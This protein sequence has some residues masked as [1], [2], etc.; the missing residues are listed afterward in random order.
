MN[1]MNHKT[2]MRQGKQTIMKEKGVFQKK[3][4]NVSKVAILLIYLVFPILWIRQQHSLIQM[5]H[6]FVLLSIL[7]GFVF[8]LVSEKENENLQFHMKWFLQGYLSGV[9][10]LL[11]FP[12]LPQEAWPFPVIALIL[13]LNSDTVLAIFAYALFLAGTVI[14]TNAGIAVFMLYFIAGLATI[15]FFSKVDKEYKIGIPL[16][17]SVS[18]M[19]MM[20]TANIMSVADPIRK[21][22]V[23]LIPLINIFVTVL[24]SLLYLKFYSFGRIHKYRE[25]YMEINDQEYKLIVSLKESSRENYFHAIHTSYFCDKAV[26]LIGGDKD[27]SRALGYYHRLQDYI[28]IKS[29]EESIEILQQ[30]EFPPELIQTLIHYQ[31]PDKSIIDKEET[32]VYFADAVISAVMYLIKKNPETELNYDKIV[33]AIFQKK[34]ES[35]CL[36]N[37]SLTLEEVYLLE[38]MFMKEKLY[39]DFLR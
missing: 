12:F 37:C 9:S 18:V 33:R 16:F 34:L 32:I 14:I 38:T 24:L 8:F 27:L 5:V 4:R 3:S 25:K 30:Y 26:N 39:Y 35:N 7:A 29:T 17:L 11:L 13:V 19:V 23:F 21:T 10:G 22:E 15:L 31:K 28:G 1:P 6:L 20:L 2:S 36:K